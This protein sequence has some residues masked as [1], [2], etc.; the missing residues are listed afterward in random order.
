MITEERSKIAP[1]SSTFSE[2]N[3]DVESIGLFPVWRGANVSLFLGHGALANP[4]WTDVG[5]KTG[6]RILIRPL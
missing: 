1:K 6:C 4:R 2:V 5:D 3:G